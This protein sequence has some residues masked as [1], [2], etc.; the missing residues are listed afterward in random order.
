MD[1]TYLISDTIVAKLNEITVNFQ[2]VEQC[3]CACWADVIITLIIC[4][5]IAAIAIVAC[6][7][8]LKWKKD[9]LDK[10]NDQKKLERDWKIEDLKREQ[11]AEYR[12]K[13]LDLQNDNSK[14]IELL[15]GYINELK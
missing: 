4:G 10:E 3:E 7:K 14:S 15:N 6:I 12:K 8:F 13:V 11:I 2:P 9:Q 5:M 1:T